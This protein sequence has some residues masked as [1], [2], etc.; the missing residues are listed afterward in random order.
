MFASTKKFFF[1]CGL[2]IALLK[3]FD[4]Q[5]GKLISTIMQYY[6]VIVTR[7]AQFRQTGK[8]SHSAE[9]LL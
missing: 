9:S 5:T 7:S 2:K 3:S 1:I 4:E 6:L 8:V